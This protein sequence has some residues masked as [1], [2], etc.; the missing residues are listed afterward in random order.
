MFAITEKTHHILPCQVVLAEIRLTNSFTFNSL[1]FDVVQESLCWIFVQEKLVDINLLK[2]F[3]HQGM[4][5]SRKDNIQKLKC[6]YTLVVGYGI[7]NNITVKSA[8]VYTILTFNLYLLKSAT[9]YFFYYFIF[10]END[11]S[12]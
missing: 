11:N 1:L 9:H 4:F 7:Q 5:Y 2:C 3:V 6:S 10:V 8:S 12:D